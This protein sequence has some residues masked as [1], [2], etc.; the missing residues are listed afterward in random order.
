MISEVTILWI[1]REIIGL[2]RDVNP[3][4]K[5]TISDKLIENDKLRITSDH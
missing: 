1:I 3:W 5:P 2:L 4:A